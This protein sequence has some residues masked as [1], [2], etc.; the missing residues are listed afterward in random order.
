MNTFVLVNT[1]YQYRDV[2]VVVQGPND[3]DIDLEFKTWYDTNVFEIIGPNSASSEWI[4]LYREVQE[5]MSMLALGRTDATWNE[6]F[7]VHLV[8]NHGFEK[9]EFKVKEFYPEV[10]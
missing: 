4:A 9:L 6:I 10:H 8:E 3:F 7:A 1:D 2:T 5:S